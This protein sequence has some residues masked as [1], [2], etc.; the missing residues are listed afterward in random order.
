LTEKLS[1]SYLKQGTWTLESSSNVNNKLVVN[2]RLNS[3]RTVNLF[4]RGNSF[5]GGDKTTSSNE[6]KV[7]SGVTLNDVLKNASDS[8]CARF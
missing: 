1:S 3:V 7:F 5:F 8:W 2:A 4:F 6:L